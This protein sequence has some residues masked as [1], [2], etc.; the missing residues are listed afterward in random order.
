MIN[1]PTGLLVHR[2]ALDAHEEDAALQ[3]LR[4]QLGRPV[5]PAHRLDKGTSGVLAFALSA[6][7]ASQ[8]GQALAGRRT[9]KRYLALARG[10]PRE[11]AGSVDHA[12]ARDPELP[13]R[14]QPLLDA[15]T[16][17]R[18]LRR[19]ELPLAT[20]ARFP[21]TRLALLACEPVQGRRHQIRRHLKHL[22]HPLIGDANY[23]KGP[24]NRALAA[25]L[26]RQRLWLHALQ[27][28]LDHPV[29][30]EPLR[31]VAPPG[32]EWAPFQPGGGWP[33]D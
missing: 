25:H 22:A 27:L 19:L 11:D 31:L 16:D 7:V 17:W 1:K 21:T 33:L 32:E 13:S 15:Q 30:G 23:G 5:W 24:L 20:D 9:R 2:S 4:D 6:A 3:R 12:L 29:T 18:C 26:G 10:W 14:G 28:E 8:L